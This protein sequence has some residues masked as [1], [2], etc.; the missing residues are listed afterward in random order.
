LAKNVWSSDPGRRRSN[1]GKI[2]GAIAVA[3][4]AI[5][6]AAYQWWPPERVDCE[7]L[8]GRSQTALDQADRDLKA[9]VT[10]GATAKCNAYRTRVTALTELAKLPAICGPPP[11]RP[12]AWPSP[13]D[14]R[15]WFETLIFEECR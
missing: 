15:K 6:G 10:A 13:N 1:R 2:F 8:V 11:K 12:G 14:E 5:G 9:A 3:T 7:T 4:V